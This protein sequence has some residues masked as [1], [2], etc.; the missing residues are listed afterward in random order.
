MVNKQAQLIYKIDP[1]MVM[2]ISCIVEEINS[3]M[4]GDA[5]KYE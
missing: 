1:M 3:L 5:I 4:P 2:A